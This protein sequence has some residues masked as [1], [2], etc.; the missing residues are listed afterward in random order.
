MSLNKFTDTKKGEDLKLKVGASALSASVSLEPP[1]YDLASLPDASSS[2][3]RVIYCSDG[4]AGNPC[5]AFSDGEN[6]LRSDNLNPVSGG[7]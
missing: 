3:G 2:T 1:A 4:G 7:G 5:L 6:W